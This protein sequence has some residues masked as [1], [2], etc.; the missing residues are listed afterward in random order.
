MGR[1]GSGVEEASDGLDFEGGSG[2]RNRFHDADT[3]GAAE[4]NEDDVARKEFLVGG[5]GQEAGAGAEDFCRDDLV[6]HRS[7]I[8]FLGR[9]IGQ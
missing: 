1:K 8:T 6:E 5:I 2:V 3:G 4:G 9:K 7:I